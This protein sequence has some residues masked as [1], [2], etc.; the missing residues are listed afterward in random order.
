MHGLMGN[1]FLGHDYRVLAVDPAWFL[2][3]LR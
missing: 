3:T 1:G 2:Q